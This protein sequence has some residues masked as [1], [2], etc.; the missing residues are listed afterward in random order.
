MAKFVWGAD[1]LALQRLGQPERKCPLSVPELARLG[2]PA[3]KIPRV[4]AELARLADVL[5]HS[6]IETTRIYLVSTGAEH[7][8]QLNSLRLIL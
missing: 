5:G 8:K 1:P 7:E 6:S 2:I 4:Q 3:R